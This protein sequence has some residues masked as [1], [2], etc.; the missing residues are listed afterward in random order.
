MY[1]RYENIFSCPNQANVSRFRA[2]ESFILW[3]PFDIGYD[4]KVKKLILL[5]NLVIPVSF[6]DKCQPSM[7]TFVGKK[8]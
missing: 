1:A 2:A 8:Y 5:R 4:Q 7:K 3:I 6:G